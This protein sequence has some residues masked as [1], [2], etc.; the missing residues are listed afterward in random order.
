MQD[1][2]KR[3]PKEAVL[4]GLRGRDSFSM[5]SSTKTKIKVKD[6]KEVLLQGK[7]RLAPG[8]PAPEEVTAML[9]ELAKSELITAVFPQID[10]A[11]VMRKPGPGMDEVT[12][13]AKASK[14]RW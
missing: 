10:G 1:V 8:R 5:P 7:L 14:P 4:F 3:L 6:T 13:F 12:F 2:S 9:D 11:N